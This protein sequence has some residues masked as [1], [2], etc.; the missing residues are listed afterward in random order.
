MKF[1]MIL[2]LLMRGRRKS[3]DTKLTCF[4]LNMKI[5]ICLKMK[6]QMKC[7]LGSPRSI[8]ALSSLGDKIDNDQKIR[9]VIRA[10]PKSQEVKAT[11]LKELNDR[12]EMD[13]SSFIGNLKAHEMEMKV[14]EEREAPK[15][16][17]VAFNVTLS[18]FDDV[19]SLI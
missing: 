5:F 10:L 7:L 18:S 12:E 14:R 4:A 15:N 1:G 8:I 9:K 13:F 6:V 11:T 16:K 19:I 3:R 17:A 2:L